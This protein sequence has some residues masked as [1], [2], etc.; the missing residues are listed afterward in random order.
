MALSK[1]AYQWHRGV[2]TEDILLDNAFNLTEMALTGTSL[3]LGAPE[4]AT[5]A[6]AVWTAGFVYDVGTFGYEWITENESRYVAYKKFSEWSPIYY[7]PNLD[8][9]MN[10]MDYV[11]LDHKTGAGSIALYGVESEWAKAFNLIQEKHKNDP[12]KITAALKELLES[13][14][15]VFWNTDGSIILDFLKQ[16]PAGLF[17]GSTMA[18]G[19]VWPTVEEEAQ[20]KAAY[21]QRMKEFLRPV[22]KAMAHKMLLEL[23]KHLVKAVCDAEPVLNNE[24]EFEIRDK[25]LQEGQFFLSSPF[26]SM[27]ITLEPLEQQATPREWICAE[28]QE[29][30]NTV[31][32]CTVYNYLKAGSPR[33]MAFWEPG[34]G[35]MMTLA[36]IIGFEV[37]D[38]KTTVVVGD[39][40]EIGPGIYAGSGS[41]KTVLGETFGDLLYP[42]IRIARTDQGLL[43]G[44]CLE[45]GSYDP[46]WQ[47]GCVPKPGTDG[48]VTGTRRVEDGKSAMTL[49]VDAYAFG[50]GARQRVTVMISQTLHQYALTTNYSWDVELKG[51]LAGES[52]TGQA[53]IRS[54]RTKIQ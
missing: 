53:S 48:W 36:T 43:I 40:A 51:A 22:M 17:G 45:D 27:H 14:L 29:K 19:W 38:P 23:E 46:N 32:C 47:V 31:F 33:Q 18:D 52:I 39:D 10:Y 21:R 37:S 26:A 3:A 20:Y 15:G 34:S 30:S 25:N 5:A 24:L 54:L 28:R 2:A 41:G 35:G 6:A 16:Q 7:V 11:E 44:P 50:T 4:L 1:I 42:S 13:Y 49:V 8:T 12:R 9:C